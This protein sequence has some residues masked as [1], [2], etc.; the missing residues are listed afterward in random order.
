VTVVRVGLIALALALAWTGCACSKASRPVVESVQVDAFEGTDVVSMTQAHLKERVIQRLEASRFILLE[1]GK[2]V[3]EGASPWV[4]KVAAGLSEPEAD[5]DPT[6]TIQVVLDLRQKGQMEAFEVRARRTAALSGNDVEAIQAAAREA[7]DAALGEVVR[8]AKALIELAALK[9]DAVAAQLTSS[10]ESVQRAAVRVLAR[11][12]D[13]R[14]LKP[15]LARL[16]T[17]D[18]TQVRET[19]GLLIELGN[20]E[21]VPALINA[22]RARDN[23]VQR[24]IVFALGAIGGDEAE[25]YLDV[26]ATGHDDPFVRASAEQALKEL[27]D[28]HSRQGAPK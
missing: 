24:E 27:K 12:K 20:P 26:V 18:L 3:P 21:A 13:A 7:L 8:E 14:A 2:P 6:S 15:L 5:D 9:D 23:V 11:R 22:S 10:D 19:M 17:D 25:A 16:E 4:I 1:P 28:R